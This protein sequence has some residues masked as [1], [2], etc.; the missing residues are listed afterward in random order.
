MF[1]AFIGL[2][3]G[4]GWH[5]EKRFCFKEKAVQMV[6][7]QKLVFLLNGL[8]GNRITPLEAY[9]F[10][11]GV[12]RY[13]DIAFDFDEQHSSELKS[14]MQQN[15]IADFSS[16]P[17]MT[18]VCNFF[19]NAFSIQKEAP[20]ITQDPE[21]LISTLLIYPPHP[22]IGNDLAV[23][24]VNLET[25]LGRGVWSSATITLEIIHRQIEACKIRMLKETAAH[26]SRYCAICGKEVAETSEPVEGLPGIVHFECD[27]CTSAIMDYD[28][29]T[30][31]L[32]ENRGLTSKGGVAIPVR[33]P[34]EQKRLNEVKEAYKN[35]SFS[36]KV[37][38]DPKIDECFLPLSEGERDKLIKLAKQQESDSASK[39]EIN[40][41]EKIGSA[42][43]K[44]NEKKAKAKADTTKKK[45]SKHHR[46]A[47]HQ[48]GEH[49]VE[50]GKE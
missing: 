16:L 2:S 38:D 35:R 3:S 47:L 48:T 28:N 36:V 32:K 7:N 42:R 24:G 13:F 12:A 5:W 8:T 44:R 31:K 22:L 21:T 27:A 43:K 17:K 45:H 26:S 9:Q 33:S 10:S 6:T 25:L 19:C 41:S 49:G 30:Q 34:E 37:G 50:K 14:F 40:E 1:K 4:N 39:R 20:F 23:K 46:K 18:G 11:M 15:F 29:R